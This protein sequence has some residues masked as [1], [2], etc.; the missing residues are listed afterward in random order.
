ML[1]S[2]VHWCPTASRAVDYNLW[3]WQLL[4]EAPAVLRARCL[5]SCLWV[6]RGP[7]G[8]ARLNNFRSL[9]HNKH[10]F[11]RKGRK[12]PQACFFPGVLRAGGPG[13]GC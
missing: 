8:A 9:Q 11:L 7:C 6:V 12:R 10:M 4:C 5:S 2:V 13:R 1:K 3:Q